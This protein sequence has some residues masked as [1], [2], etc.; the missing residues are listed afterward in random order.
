MRSAAAANLKTSK[1]HPVEATENQIST[2]LGFKKRFWHKGNVSNII[3]FVVM[4]VGI[5]LRYEGNLIDKK[6]TDIVLSF[7]IFG[8]SGGIT[9]W[10][11]IKMLF[12]KVPLLVGSGVIT[13]KFKEIREAFKTMIMTMFFDE[14][15]LKRYFKTKGSEFFNKLKLEEKLRSLVDDPDV[16]RLIDVKLA[17]F[18]QRPEAMFLTMFNITPTHL[19]SVV[20]PFAASFA[21]QAV[22]IIKKIFTE[23]SDETFS[24]LKIEIDRLMRSKLKEMSPDD[25][26]HLIEGIIRE[27]LGWLIIWGNVFGG[28]IGIITVLVGY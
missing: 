5:F 2:G 12:D 7:G 18:S 14:R 4:C 19:K 24:W 21:V 27:H 3:F 17:E 16:D 6:I 28:I 10:L 26:K 1:Q 8:F 13:H 23:N 20:K 15:F 22:P 25:V 11:A 9:N